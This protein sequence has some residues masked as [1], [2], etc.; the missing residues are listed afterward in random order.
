M[1]ATECRVHAWSNVDGNI[2][3]ENFACTSGVKTRTVHLIQTSAG[4][5]LVTMSRVFG[6]RVSVECI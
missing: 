3:L 2:H 5:F 4:C 1:W 6:F